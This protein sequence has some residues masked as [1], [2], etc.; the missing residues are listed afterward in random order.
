[1]KYNLEAIRLMLMF[2]DVLDSSS[3]C[4]KNNVK[5]YKHVILSYLLNLKL[6]IARVED[7]ATSVG[8]FGIL[9]LIFQK[10]R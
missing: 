2:S 4:R 8:L 3:G 1:M 6:A 7:V 5:F 9:A 10:V